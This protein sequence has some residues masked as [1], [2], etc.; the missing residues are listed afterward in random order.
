MLKG[1]F[2]VI[3]YY[4]AGFALA[5]LVYAAE[6][7]H[8]AHGPGPRELIVFLTLVIGVVWFLR[9]I[10]QYSISKSE[11]SKGGMLGHLIVLFGF[12]VFLFFITNKRESTHVETPNLIVEENG[13]TTTAYHYGNPVYYKVKD[14]VFI[15]FIDSSRVDWNNVEY[16]KK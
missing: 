1:L 12:A 14:S 10:V 8:Y 2:S 5:W 4:A 9:T 16:R 11:K 15:N 13:D 3:V 6:E 7:T